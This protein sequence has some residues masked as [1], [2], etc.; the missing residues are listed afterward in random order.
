M[1]GVLKMCSVLILLMTI[2][3]N[4]FGAEDPFPPIIFS[5]LLGIWEGVDGYNVYRLEIIDR[6]HAKLAISTATGRA[7]L[8]S[9]TNIH[10]ESIKLHFK[11]DANDRFVT[12]K[13][14]GNAGID[15]GQ[16]KVNCQIRK[17][18]KI[19][20]TVEVT[21]YKDPF[22]NSYFETIWNNFQKIKDKMSDP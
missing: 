10:I 22:N 3:N 17:T 1:N 16:M 9:L 7:L 4:S 5:T 21:L 12:I 19:I 13:G 20:S 18:D 2:S 6:K 14:A 11:N 15:Q 8:Y